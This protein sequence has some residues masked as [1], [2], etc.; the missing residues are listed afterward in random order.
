MIIETIE[1]YREELEKDPT[2][3]SMQ[4]RYKGLCNWKTLTVL[5]SYDNV[6]ITGE[7]HQQITHDLRGLIEAHCLRMKPPETRF[8]ELHEIAN[9]I[10]ENAHKE[11][12]AKKEKGKLKQ[13]ILTQIGN[14]MSEQFID[15]VMQK[16]HTVIIIRP[17]DK[18]AW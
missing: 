12:M 5:R 14:T 1:E 2:G 15:E 17:T 7:G 13:D 6:V 9:E 10:S 3:K 16:Q 11:A 18:D 4:W 8:K